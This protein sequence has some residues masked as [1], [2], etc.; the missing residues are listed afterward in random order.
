MN[1]ELVEKVVLSTIYKIGSL[2]AYWEMEKLMLVNQA[3]EM[4]SAHSKAQDSASSKCRVC[5]C[6]LAEEEGDDLV[7]GVC[8]SCKERPEARRLG[9]AALAS[10]VHS[11]TPYSLPS[12]KTKLLPAAAKPGFLG[13]R[14][15]SAREF[16]VAEKALIRKMHGYVPA[17]QLLALLNERLVCDLGEDA[18]PYTME[19]LHD[20]IGE[21][22]EAPAGTNDW[23]NLRKL[24]AKASRSGVLASITEQTINDFAVVFSLNARQVLH[25]KD[26]VLSAKK[27]RK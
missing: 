21:G 8:L 19:Q 23:A 9:I 3:V 26:V 24:L 16:T 2:V 27:D 13:N 5:V 11:I 18:M 17:P 10:P 1:Y 12:A 7:N 25:L 14:F 20:Q 22:T 6:T 4:S 15:S